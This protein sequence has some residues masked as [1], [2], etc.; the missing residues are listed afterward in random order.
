MKRTPRTLLFCFALLVWSAVGAQAGQ[1]EDA[2]A[3]AKSG[4]YAIVLTLLRPLAERGNAASQNA[5]GGMYLNGLGL[6]QDSAAAAGWYRKAAEQGNADAQTQLGDMYAG[7]EGVRQEYKEALKWWQLA[8]AQG[9][10]RALNNLGVMHENGEGV[11][12]DYVRAH[13]WF[14]VAAL[15]LQGERRKAAA[16][17]R[18]AIAAKMTPTQIEQAQALAR[19]C[20]QSNYRECD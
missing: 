3:A 17:N 6:A 13:M 10:A 16:D 1:Y 12:Q 11:A 9:N 18:D 4:D 5:L 14:N 8:A 2:I 15:S 20:L 19:T 7:G